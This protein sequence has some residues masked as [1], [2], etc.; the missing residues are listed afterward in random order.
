M[1]I[2]FIHN[3]F[4]G[5]YRRITNYLEQFPEYEMTAASLITNKQKSP[6]LKV[7]YKPHREPTPTIHP[8]L[9]STERAVITG[10]AAYGQF[11][12]YKKKY[13]SPDIILAHSG[14]G[15]SLFLKDIFPDAKLLTYFEWYYHCHGSDGEFLRDEP[16]GPIDEIRLRMKN[17]PILHDLAAMDWGQCPTKFQHSQLPPIFR[18]NVSVL[19]D[20]VD[21]DYFS[22]E[23]AKGKTVQ[24]TAITVT[25]GKLLTAD[26]EVITYVARGME[27]YRGF[28][29]FM[30]A[31]SKL[32]KLRPNLHVVVL[33][34]DRVAYGANRSDGKTFK[35]WA[36]KEFELDLARIHFMGLMPLQYF[37]DMMRITKAHIYLTAP[38]VL[39]WSM[40]EAMSA[41]ALIIGSDTDPVSEVITHKQNGLLVPFFDVDAQVH[42]ITEVLEGKV[43]VAP[44]KENARDTIV[45][46]YSI[47]DLLPQYRQLIETVANGSQ[48]ACA[49]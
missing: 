2:L 28:P 11:M 34:D 7:G 35:Q 44:I 23:P 19:H 47:K 13:P 1:R 40:M 22:P 48:K 45:K 38:F 15:A 21:V 14:W 33:G 27:E 9:V 30:E 18:K 37:R 6:Y 16:Y 31:V 42:Q 17:T 49:T 24:K 29:Q 3:N 36:L 43:D 46:N 10:Q 39:S 41:G 20:G 25:D 4:P 26:D 8:S 12:D 5:Q 32:Q